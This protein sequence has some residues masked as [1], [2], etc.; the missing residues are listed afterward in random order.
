MYERMGMGEWDC[1]LLDYS[2]GGRINS[3]NKG[4]TGDEVVGVKEIVQ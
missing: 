2:D 3:E 1:D 4:K